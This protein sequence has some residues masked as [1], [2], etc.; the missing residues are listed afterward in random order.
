VSGPE[1]DRQTGLLV[2]IK[3]VDNN[4]TIPDDTGVGITIRLRMASCAASVATQRACG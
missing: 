1:V 3:A 2:T 4:R